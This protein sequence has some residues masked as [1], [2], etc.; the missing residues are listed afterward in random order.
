M[1]NCNTQY[2]VLFCFS[3][4]VLYFI[5]PSW[6][7]LHTIFLGKSLINV[8]YPVARALAI[9]GLTLYFSISV[10]LINRYFNNIIVN[11]HLIIRI[12]D[13]P[14]CIKDNLWL[15]A[16]CCL[17]AVLHIYPLSLVLVTTGGG[18]LPYLYQPL[19][20]YD[21]LNS[22]WHGLFNVPVQYLF[23]SIIV[24]IIL[25]TKQNKLINT[26][27][28]YITAW[29][30][31][32][33]SNNVIKLFFITLMFSIF[34]L[35]SYLFPYYSRVESVQ[36][37]RYPPV[38]KLI[39]LINYFAFGVSFI[40]PRI[41]QLI[42][43]LMGAVYLYRTIQLFRVKETA[44]LG[45]TIYLFSPIIFSYASRAAYASGTVFFIILISFYFLRFIK[46]ADNRDLLLTTYFIGIGFL[47]K[48]VLLLM[49]IICFAY[50]I[51]SVI[52][53]RD[54]YAIIH[55]KILLL[56]L[57]PILPWLKIAPSMYFPVWTNLITFNELIEYFVMIQS[58]ISLIIF[59]MLISALVYAVV[60]IKTDLSKYF[61]LLFIAYY[62]FFTLTEQGDVNH[63]YV[64]ALYPAIVVF[65]AQFLFAITQRIRWKHTFKLFLLLLTVYLVIICLIPRSSSNITTFK[66][67]DFES[68]YYSVDKVADWIGEKAGK[69]E[70]ILV[71]FMQNY[72]FYLKRVYKDKDEINPD[73]FIV[74]ADVVSKELLYNQQN[75]RKYCYDEKVSYI[76]IPFG[77][78]NYLPSEIFAERKEI[79]SNFIEHVGMG[80]EFDEVAKF[81]LDDNY[82]LIFKPRGTSEYLRE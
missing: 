47:Y 50:L 58:Q 80:N 77:P 13:W 31:K 61:G 81:S 63:R 78:R 4:I 28:N 75:L 17:S 59:L 7:S 46:Y 9:F 76:V 26:V 44:L 68:Q 82:L 22:Y 66:Y 6:I 23:W 52:K 60:T 20:I 33:K 73:R 71:L 55:F 3:W 19:K 32:Y 16:V 8:S 53:K 18:E 10:Y 5:F 37:V 38:S 69:N 34:C 40:G 39:Y 35:Y 64:M 14:K 67:K 2:K 70:K 36:L 11:K 42:L 72:D 56:S 1:K 45:A 79:I 29:F 48:R 21:V 27:S 15:I 30:S 65:L 51:L 74:L 25:L 12:N 62:F 24:L 43:Y 54:Q 57:V 41:I 49:F